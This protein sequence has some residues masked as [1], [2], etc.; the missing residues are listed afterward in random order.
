[1]R[2]LSLE[3]FTAR[4]SQEEVEFADTLNLIDALY[5][6]H[7]C[8]FRSGLGD[9]LFENPAGQNQGACKVFAFGLI[10]NLIDEAVL[11][12]FGEHYRA[13]LADP[14]GNDHRNIRNFMAYGWGGIEFD[15]MPL[16]PKAH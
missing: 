11:A 10:N 9:D 14:D 2:P 3:E 4:L 12:A 5:D 15:D 1:M 13:V 6:Y 8:A 16:R 7:P